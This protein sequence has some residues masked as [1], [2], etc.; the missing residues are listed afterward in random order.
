MDDI[1]ESPL[2]TLGGDATT[3]AEHRGKVLLLVNVASACG[4]TPQYEG[5]EKLYRDGKDAGLVVMGFP[6]NQFGAQEPGTDAEIASFCETRFAVSFPMYSKIDVNGPD[7]HPVY[8]H[9]KAALDGAEVKWNFEK[10]LVSREGK[11]VARFPSNA[12]PEELAQ[13]IERLL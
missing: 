10:F 9:A 5:L 13:E 2:K 1:F 7:A 8:Q 12:K 6:C 3:L 11:V 4:F